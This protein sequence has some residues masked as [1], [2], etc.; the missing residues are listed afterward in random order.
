MVVSTELSEASIF[1]GFISFVS[2][3]LTLTRVLWSE[4]STLADA[5]DQVHLALSNLK[6]ALFEEREAVRRISQVQRRN[7]RGSHPHPHHQH[8]RRSSTASRRIA[9]DKTPDSVGGYGYATGM[10]VKIMR[11]SIRTLCQ[12]FTEVERPFLGTAQLSPREKASAN[13][14][15][16]WDAEE[17]ATRY[18]EDGFEN[19][20]RSMTLGLRFKWLRSKSQVE[21]L[22]VLLN[23][24]QMRR[25]AREVMDGLMYVQEETKP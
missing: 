19:D 17:T 21:A 16:N 4:I 24:F 7:S 6:E 5:P 14:N 2:T 8:R 18:H 3:L 1:I 12:R 15:Y 10:D 25:I 22:W 13:A 20:Y 11:E 23:R 9:Y